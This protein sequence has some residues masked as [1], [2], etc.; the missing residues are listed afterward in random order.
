MSK[1]LL[2]QQKALPFSQLSRS[3]TC[4]AARKKTRVKKAENKLVV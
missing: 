4:D 1:K 3:I 2:P